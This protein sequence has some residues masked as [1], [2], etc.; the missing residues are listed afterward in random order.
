MVIIIWV[1]IKWALFETESTTIITVSN[2]V[3]FGSFTM[4]LMLVVFH[5]IF[6][7]SSA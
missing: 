3:N 7:I 5:L 2:S 4:K 6:G 1:E